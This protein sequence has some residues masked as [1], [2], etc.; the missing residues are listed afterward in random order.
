MNNVTPVLLSVLLVL[1]LPA[2]TGGMM[3]PAPPSAIDDGSSADRQQ[4]VAS[5]QPPAEIANTTNRLPVTG[6]V[7]SEVTEYRPDLGMGLTIADDEL[8]TDYEQYTIIDSKFEEATAEERAALIQAAY[9]QLE[10][11]AGELEQREREVVQAHAAGDQSTTHLLQVLVRNHNEAAVLSES[12]NQ[13]T[14]QADQVAGYSLPSNQIRTTQNAFREHQSPIRERLSQAATTPTTD[15]Q[16]NV[17]ISTSEAGYS[18]SMMQGSTYVVETTRF[19]NRD[20]SAPDQFDDFE[21]FE[22][23]LELY[24]WASE[25]GSPHFQDNSPDHYWTEISHSQGQLEV[26]LDPGTG[27]VYREVQELRAPS[28][29]SEE[30]SP[31]T[32]DGLTMTMNRTPADGPIEVTVTDQD[33]GEP[34]N[35]LVT[36]A[37]VNVGQTGADGI[38]WVVPPLGSHDLEATTES[39]V[40]NATVNR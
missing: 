9:E 31:W 1:S 19:D 12:L 27:E 29:P 7:R 22:R 4:Q 10:Q 8:R 36:V 14:K 39:G 26:Y 17:V 30:V 16:Y 35:A 34:V 24:P 37:G 2:I 5:Q 32:G 11:R 25:Q 15:N 23:T 18:L 20:K 21:G 6:N 3:S 40:V 33:T 13:L 38:L 28:L